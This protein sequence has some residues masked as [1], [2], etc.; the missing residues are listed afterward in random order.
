MFKLEVREKGTTNLAWVHWSL[1]EIRVQFEFDLENDLNRKKVLFHSHFEWATIKIHKLSWIY[2]N[3]RY[4]FQSNS[5]LI[6][7][8]SLCKWAFERLFIYC[9][10]YS[11]KVGGEKFKEERTRGRGNA[12]G[13]GWGKMDFKLE[14]ELELEI[15]A[16]S[17]RCRGKFWLSCN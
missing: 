3:A 15:G 6:F 16:R 14:L 10:Q 7:K 4:I 11:C 2:I 9:I 13:V 17:W 1:D 12:N 8:H 5:N